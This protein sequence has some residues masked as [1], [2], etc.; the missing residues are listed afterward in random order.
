VKVNA[1]AR[2]QRSAAIRGGAFRGAIGI[3]VLTFV[4]ATDSLLARAVS[5]AAEALFLEGRRLLTAGQTDQACAR[6]AESYAAEASSGTL[7][8]LALCHEKQGKLATAWAEYR[9][10]T[11]LARSQGREDRAAVAGAKIAE[12]DRKLSR[13]TSIPSKPV[14]GL[15][16]ATEDGTLGEGGLGVAVPIDPGLHELTVSAPGYRSWVTTVVIQPGEQRVLEIPELQAE[17]APTVVPGSAVPAFWNRSGP[18]IRGTEGSRSTVGPI[19][20]LSSVAL[21]GLVVGGAFGLKYRSEN[22][23]AKTLC[24]SNVCRDQSERDRHQGLM[25]DAQR[26]RTIGVVVAVAGGVALLTASY[27]WWRSAAPGPVPRPGRMQLSARIVD[28]PGGLG[29]EVG[30]QW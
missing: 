1:G 25:T 6:F 13:L 21:V 30:L 23:E 26:D 29:G 3:L 5:P 17:P 24:P 19:V 9:G 22:D 2:R 10:A 27:L 7:L 15:R 16:I 28:R 8:N 18:E 11:R 20:A 12:L 14:K 4:I